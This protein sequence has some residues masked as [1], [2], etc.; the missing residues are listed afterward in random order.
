MAG[1]RSGGDRNRHA[2]RRHPVLRCVVISL[3][4]LIIL[5]GLIVLIF[6]LIV[7]P[8]PID[9]TVDG[10]SIR[11]FNLSS[12]NSLD[13]TFDLTLRADNRNRRVSVY[14]DWIDVGVWYD[15]EMVA[16]SELSP[17]YQP[18]RNV[19]RLETKPTAVAVS[20]PASAAKGL[21]HD[22]SAGEVEVEVRVRGRVRFKVGLVKTRHYDL[23]AYCSPVIIRFSSSTS[24]DRV[25]C[26]VD[27]DAD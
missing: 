24:F 15:D 23:N 27:F 7:R 3:L 12:T 18:K 22:R 2:P 21:K 17:F 14:Y 10:A 8:M 13:A 4:T 9:Y 11:G 16:L 20:L 26:D 1:P 6:W 25:Y 19:T 5:T